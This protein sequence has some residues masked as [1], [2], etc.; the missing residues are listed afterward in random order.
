MAQA[1]TSNPTF[2]ATAPARDEVAPGRELPPLVSEDWL[3]VLVGAALIA[4]VLIG[5][6][7]VSPRFAWGTPQAPVGALVSA[8]NVARSAQTVLLV[9]GPADCRRR[10]AARATCWRSFRAP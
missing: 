2:V 6:R 9:L 1:A 10:R 5:V 3:A 7:P 4:L 8:D